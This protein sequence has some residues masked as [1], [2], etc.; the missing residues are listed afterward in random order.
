MVFPCVSL[1][2]NPAYPRFAISQKHEQV[3]HDKA[4]GRILVGN[5]DVSKTLLVGADFIGT[6]HDKHT[7]VTQDAMGFMACLEIKV[8]NRFMVFLRG[9]I[10]SIVVSIVPFIIL[11]VDVSSPAG[12]VHVGRIE[13]HAIKAF[14]SIR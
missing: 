10:A 7:V 3:F 9:A 2:E 4:V 5:F 1:L 11:M 14:I 8:K 12:S 6:L 13:D